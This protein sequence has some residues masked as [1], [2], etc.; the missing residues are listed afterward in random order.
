L[1]QEL[2]Y[3][4]TEFG[5]MTL[6]VRKRPAYGFTIVEMLVV[7]AVIGVIASIT[8]PTIYG[9]VLRAKRGAH[10]LEVDTIADAVEKYK[11]KYGDYP[12]DGSSWAVMERHLRK[13][14]PQILQSELNLLNPA[15]LSSQGWANDPW[16]PAAGV[17]AGI[18][19]DYDRRFGRV[20]DPAEALVFFLGGFSSDPQ[21][22]FTGQGGPFV[23][24]GAASGQT[25]QYNGSRANA[26]YEFNAGRLTTQVV[27][28]GNFEFLASNDEVNYHGETPDLLPVYLANGSD[29]NR[30]A[31]IVYFDRRSYWLDVSLPAV[32]ALPASPSPT[33]NYYQCAPLGASTSSSG[34]EYGSI[35]PLI[36]DAKRL[37]PTPMIGNQPPTLLF[38]E[39]KKFQVISPGVDGFY[40]GRLIAEIPT[41]ER[42]LAIL[43]FPGGDS[44]L[45]STNAT[46][47]FKAWQLPPSDGSPGRSTTDYKILLKQSKYTLDNCANFSA[48]IFSDGQP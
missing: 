25:L 20:M 8:I 18:R 28:G 14:F 16:T 15:T 36:S 13:A 10:K 46:F 26:F 32:G 37:P 35:R 22:P 27:S 44:Y 1:Y 3:Q 38:M 42:G 23:V 7:I 31:P 40:G 29:I 5:V 33:S 24:T 17:I 2:T 41:N 30:S 45:G 47:S 4:P 11:N 34:R 9:A 6:A 43:Q 48:T 12:P 39:E 21:R 19:N